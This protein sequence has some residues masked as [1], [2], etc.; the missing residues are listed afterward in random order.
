MLI[1]VV[2]FVA[3]ATVLTALAL[4]FKHRWVWAI[5]APACWA[6]AALNFYSRL[7]AQGTMNIIAGGIAVWNAVNWRKHDEGKP[8]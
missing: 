1:R 5:Y 2:D 4:R 6:Y 8:D 3:A 7:P